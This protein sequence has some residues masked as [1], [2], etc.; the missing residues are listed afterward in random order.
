MK[1]AETGPMVFG[2]DWT[3]IFIRGDEAAGYY[4]AIQEL[5]EENPDLANTTPIARAQL[6]CLGRLLMRSR[7]DL[8]RVTETVQRMK[9]FEKAKV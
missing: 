3:G 5:L 7:D 2:D 4:F 1:R 8:P 9:P 6:E